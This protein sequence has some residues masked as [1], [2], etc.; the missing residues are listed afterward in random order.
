MDSCRHRK[1]EPGFAAIYSIPSDLITSTMKS[2]PGWS[3]VR[4]STLVETGSVSAARALAEGKGALPRAGWLCW[5]L[6]AGVETRAA[7]PTPAPLRKSRRSIAGFFRSF[8]GYLLLTISNHPSCSQ[9]RKSELQGNPGAYILLQFGNASRS[10]QKT[11]LSAI[12][13]IRGSP[14]DS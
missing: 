10:S 4:T 8:I 7:A 11:N 2:D 6:P 1:L 9:V 12:C 5:A 3:A 14:T 13:I